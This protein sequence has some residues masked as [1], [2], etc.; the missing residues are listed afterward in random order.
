V[1]KV[2]TLLQDLKAE[3]EQEG[4]DEASQ[5]DSFACFCKTTTMEKSSSI[6][7][8]R[9]TIDTLSTSIQEKTA[10]KE[11][12]ETEL[13]E[14][15]QD[16]E[17]WNKELTETQARFEKARAEYEATAADLS[18][19][20]SSL[21]NAVSAMEASK[22]VSL[23]GVREVVERMLASTRS[24]GVISDAKRKA[25]TQMLQ[26]KVDPAD[27]TYQYKSQGIIDTLTGLLKDFRAEKDELE[28]EWGKAKTNFEDT[29]SNLEEKIRL[30]GE[31]M[32]LLEGDIETLRVDIA[33]A[34]GDLV[35]AEALLKDDQLYLKDLTQM[36]EDRAKDWDQRSQTRA[37]EIAAL[38]EALDVLQSRVSGLDTE[39]NKRALLQAGM[40]KAAQAAKLAT[41]AKHQPGAAPSFVQLVS[42]G[43][44][45]DGRVSKLRGAHAA[46]LAAK[47][48]QEK[49]VAFLG[50]EGQRL[51][52][53]AL[54]T[55]AMHLSEDPFGEVKKLI[56][57]LIE[58]L[59]AE[60]TSE[61]TK[62]GFCDKEVSKAQEERDFRLAD[63]Q[64]LDIEIK[65]LQLK[66]D[67]L[68]SEIDLLTGEITNLQTNLDTATEDRGE[69]KKINLETIKKAKEGLA[70][71]Q[72]AIRILKAFYKQ[73][74]KAQSFAQYSPVSD[75]TSGPGF[76]GAYA[77]K[78]ERSKGVIGL[79]EVI[80]GDF[81][82]TARH[83]D[84]AEKKAHEE[85][86]EFD[87]TSR[88]DISGKETK[89][90]LDEE[91]LE[92]TKNTIE[93]K[94]DDL[95]TQQK[96]LDGA[97][98]RL[99]DLKPTCID[100]GMS[101]E[102]RVAKRQEEIDALKRALCILDTN[103]VETGCSGV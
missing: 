64:K 7:T 24:L 71:V 22:P 53:M 14:R 83:T 93:Q 96:L 100:T 56:Q 63:T 19:A 51:G 6:T 73:A 28:T 67:E 69:E 89:V 11:N 76:E 44:G 4:K 41:V 37:D 94:M 29:I 68:E 77:G 30:N 60:S 13:K 70:A 50:Q 98:R 74:G 32:D 101:Y 43:R 85:F 62:K 75:D 87:R 48:K 90:K 80:A 12:K 72:E 57:K 95:R 5:Y 78:Q 16:A 27:P 66:Q 52:S 103:G 20:I 46:S 45:N 1:S 86:V 35:S 59:L 3:V 61:A 91:D 36:C 8:G 33:T 49:V 31:A 88:A 15:K 26:A 42:D 34:R 21:D 92:T 18:K 55:L 99:R 84:V 81:D 40:A 82:R 54:S 9:D 58:R 39:V 2:I 102:D 17:A 23:V 10:L 25:A 65:G 47:A 97:L 38:T 79:L